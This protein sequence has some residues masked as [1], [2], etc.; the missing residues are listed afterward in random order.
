MP[1][2]PEIYDEILLEYE[3]KLEKAV[4]HAADQ[5]QGIRTGRAS[6][7]LVDRLN[8]EYYGSPTP[9]KQLA[10]IGV[11][12]PRTIAIKP[13]DASSIKDILRAIQT[14]DLGVNPSSDGKVVRVTLPPLSEEQRKKLAARAKTL[15]EEA[16]VALRNGRR[17]ANKANDQANAD[18]D[19]T[20]DQADKLQTEIQEKLKEHEAKVDDLLKKKTEEIL[21]I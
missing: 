3:D 4:Q 11:P 15:C 21:T 1:V 6:P 19:L 16:K 14:S 8:V 12:E 5:L 2:N 18:G 7:A 17:D 10:Q 13:F 20:D 9:L